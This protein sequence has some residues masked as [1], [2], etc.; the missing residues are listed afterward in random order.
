ML[1]QL[2]TVLPNLGLF[3]MVRLK[4]EDICWG[5]QWEAPQ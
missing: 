1:M 4:R 3:G 5:N 2:E